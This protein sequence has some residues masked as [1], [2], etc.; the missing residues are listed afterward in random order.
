MQLADDNQ[1]FGNQTDD[2]SIAMVMLCLSCY[3]KA[4]N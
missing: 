4:L 1:S 3:R 2:L